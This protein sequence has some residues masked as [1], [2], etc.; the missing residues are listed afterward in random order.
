M[1]ARMAAV[2][3]TLCLC[4]LSAFARQS[5]EAPAR[6]GPGLAAALAEAR[7]GP[8]HVV[9]VFFED[10]GSESRLSV[11]SRTVSLQAQARRERRG[12]ALER[13]AFEDRPL[14]R[15]YVEAVALRALRLR[16]E[17]RWFNAVSVEATSEQVRSLASLPFVERIEL[18]RR[19]GR[20]RPETPP[21]PHISSP[22]FWTPRRP[23]EDKKDDDDDDDGGGRRYDYGP[24][25]GQLEQIRVPA[26]HALGFDGQG[27]VIAMLDS[28]FDNLGH[29]A[30]A[31][32]TI[33]HRR[34]F[35]N[36]DDDVANGTDMGEGSHGTATLSAIG[37]FKEGQIVGPAFGATF[38]LAKTENTESET[39]VEEDHWAAAAEWAESLGADVISCSLGYLDYDSPYPSYTW[40]DMDGDTAISTRAAD[41]AAER[42]VVVVASAGN[43]GSNSNHNTLGAPADGHRVI[44]AAA[45]TSW[46]ARASFSS[47]G[48]SADGRIKPDVAAQGQDVYTAGSGHPRNYQY[49]DGTSFSCPLT[50][51]VAALVLQA[52]PRYTV[53]QVIAV[54]RSTASQAASPDNRLGWGIVDALA[55]VQAPAPAVAQTGRR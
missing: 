22:D 25:L 32:T 37:G 7:P 44:A 26:V 40:P 38:L 19:L 30:F 2:V 20:G 17:L 47:V 14:E 33:T 10:K 8:P 51:G 53:D 31:G 18:V 55:A 27:V 35:V 49:V 34:D 21:A 39:P 24:A 13:H 1:R 29:E 41:L 43:N 48:P 11:R 4:P 28:G 3:V 5:P 23:T 42:G 9:F 12:V 54:L 50:A 52:H 45:V 6:L 15:S 46:G 16:H 36:G